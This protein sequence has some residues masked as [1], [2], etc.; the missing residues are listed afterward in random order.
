M[1][2]DQRWIFPYFLQFPIFF[3]GAFYSNSHR[4]EH[5]CDK[6]ILPM[7]RLNIFNSELKQSRSE[8]KQA[9][10]TRENCS[11]L[12]WMFIRMDFTKI[13]KTWIH[14]IRETYLPSSLIFAIKRSSDTISNSNLQ[15][16]T[17]LW[18]VFSL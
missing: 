12:K 17:L 13:F 16:D 4:F 9:Q 5:N 14:S 3:H 8:W 2:I 1:A 10:N 15:E 18:R 11:N 7:G 6:A